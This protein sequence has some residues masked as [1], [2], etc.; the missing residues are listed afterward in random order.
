[1]SILQARVQTKRAELKA[2]VDVDNN[3]KLNAD[4]RAALREVLRA[5]VRQDTPCDPETSI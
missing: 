2:E 3:G 5:K 1:M 4:E